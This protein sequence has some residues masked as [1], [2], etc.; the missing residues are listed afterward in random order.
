MAG[1]EV[2]GCLVSSSDGLWETRHGPI[3]SNT[4]RPELCVDVHQVR[5]DPFDANRSACFYFD[6]FTV[7][8]SF[9]DGQHMT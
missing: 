8:K 1:I 7:P 9:G 2:G 5:P 6:F 3:V 4:Q